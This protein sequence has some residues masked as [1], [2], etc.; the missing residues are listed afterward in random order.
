MLGME[1]FWLMHNNRVRVAAMMSQDF[2]TESVHECQDSSEMLSDFHVLFIKARFV[3]EET[4]NC[5]VASV[6]SVF[7]FSNSVN[8]LRR[9]AS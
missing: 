7:K 5:G 6:Q 4:K 2:V 3:R 9:R 8:N 1:N